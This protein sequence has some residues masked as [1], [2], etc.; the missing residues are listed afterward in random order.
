VQGYLDAVSIALIVIVGV[1]APLVGWVAMQRARNPVIWFVY[2]ALTGPIALAVLLAA[3]PGRCPDC[4]ASVAGWPEACATCGAPFGGARGAIAPGDGG[5]T[6]RAGSGS[7]G[8]P[9]SGPVTT[10]SRVPVAPP[11]EAG[12]VT[13]VIA[14]DSMRTVTAVQASSA[15]SSYGPRDPAGEK[16]VATGVYLSG[17]AGMEVGALYAI[18][19]VDDLVRVFGPVDAGQLTVRFERRIDDAEITALE[20]RIIVTGRSGRSPTSI[21][22]RAVGGMR[23][24]ALEAAFATGRPED[25]AGYGSRG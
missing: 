1:F 4:D 23:G 8:R 21:V 15:S 22:M 12:K 3:P 25:R 20:D 9:G 14:S 24:D 10:R 18:A 19:R 11:Y 17:N 2:G 13:R 7:A 6:G 16:V 5:G